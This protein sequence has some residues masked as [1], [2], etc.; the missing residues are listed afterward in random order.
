MEPEAPIGRHIAECDRMYE[1]AYGRP[2]ECADTS[3]CKRL[4]AMG[5]DLTQADLPRICITECERWNLRATG[6]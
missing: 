4:L 6:F 3:V 1:S 5:V 2:D